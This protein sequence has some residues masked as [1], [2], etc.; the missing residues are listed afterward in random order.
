MIKFYLWGS[1]ADSAFRGQKR[2]SESLELELQLVV[3][4]PKGGRKPTLS[5]TRGTSVLN[6]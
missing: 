6:C 1:F 2:A 4:H 3:S 5:S